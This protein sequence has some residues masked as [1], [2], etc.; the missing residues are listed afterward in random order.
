[1]LR[2][3]ASVLRPW[4]V[5]SA[6]LG[7]SVA[8]VALAGGAAGGPRPAQPVLRAAPAPSATAPA[9]DAL[10]AT[11]VVRFIAL[12][13]A[14]GVRRAG[15]GPLPVGLAGRTRA[16]VSA[17]LAPAQV[18]GF[19]P[20]LLVVERRF[21]GCPGD[22]VTL[23][24]RDGVV[25]ALSGPPGDTGPVLRRTGIP[26]RGLDAADAARL[27][28]GWAV[29]TARLQVELDRLARAA[30]VPAPDQPG[31]ARPGA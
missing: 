12:Y 20:D 27:E 1:M 10:A 24:Q 14:C 19:A 2:A 23:V 17:A 18:V 15:S 26:V 9:G 21:P 5:L 25:V 29:P 28:A 7:L 11:A 6:A 30:G 22:T 8:V 16:D 31:A 13:P 3:E 4:L